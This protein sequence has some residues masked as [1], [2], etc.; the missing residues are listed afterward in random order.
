MNTSPNQRV[1]PTGGSRLA[2][3]VLGRQWRLPPVADAF[4]WPRTASRMRKL[5]QP[6]V[7]RGYLWIQRRCEVARFES[8]ILADVRKRNLL[9]RDTLLAALQ[10]I[11]SHDP[12]RF[13]RVKRHISWVVNCDLELGMAAEYNYDT[14]TCALDFQEPEPNSDRSVA[15]GTYARRLIHEATH[16]AVLERGIAYSPDLRARVEAL[17]VAEENRFV[18]RVARSEPELADRLRREFDPSDWDTVWTASRW[19]RA[20]AVLQQTPAG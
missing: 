18:C 4:R 19:K 16:G 10:F 11:Q 20:L 9:F 17:C 7:N 1:Q 3:A 15:V 8:I 13:A 14:R 6:L 5:I 12:R 2:Q